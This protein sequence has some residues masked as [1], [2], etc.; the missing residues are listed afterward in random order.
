MSDE[1]A[2][3]L[4]PNW[5]STGLGDAAN[6]NDP[7]KI[8]HAAGDV[9]ANSQEVEMEIAAA[10]ATDNAEHTGRPGMAHRIKSAIID[11]LSK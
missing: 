4:P 11:A 3:E 8:A 10:M 9:I 5:F 7:A 2:G 1:T 6:S